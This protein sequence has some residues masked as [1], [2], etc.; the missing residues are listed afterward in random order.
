MQHW[1]RHVPTLVVLSFGGV[2]LFYGP[3]AQPPEYHEFADRWVLFGIPHAA[4]VFSSL[5]FAAVAAWGWLGLRPMRDHPALR[6]GWYGYRLF[7]VALALTTVGS[8]YY[9]LA[10]DNA[11]LVWDRLPIALIWAG[12]LA[13]VR[14]ETVGSANNARDTAL[15]ALAAVISVAWWRVT[16]DWQGHDDLRPYVLLQGLTLVLIPLWQGLYASPRGDR[17]AYGVAWLLFGA[18]RAGEAWDRQILAALGWSSGHTLKH[19]LAAAAAAV[20]VHRLRHRIH[21]AAAVAAP[22]R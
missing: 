2:L 8:A 4:D 7:L 11:R 6:N 12:L 10:P 15:L 13:A 9:H 3:I 1:V 17:I 16:D 19:L 5:A 20:I 21:E 14:A 18:A 22:T